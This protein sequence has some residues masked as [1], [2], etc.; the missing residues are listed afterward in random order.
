[1]I[2]QNIYEKLKQLCDDYYTLQ[3]EAQKVVDDYND[4]HSDDERNKLA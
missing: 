4:S 3:A 1:M 2:Q